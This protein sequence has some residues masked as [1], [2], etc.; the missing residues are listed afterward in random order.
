MEITKDRIYN[1]YKELVSG[2]KYHMVF[3]CM[4]LPIIGLGYLAGSILF[5]LVISAIF[6]IGLIIANAFT[7]RALRK[8][9]NDEFVIYR[10]VC[11][12]KA[13]GRRYKTQESYFRIKSQNLY[14]H[15]FNTIPIYYNE[16]EEGQPFVAVYVGKRLIWIYNLTTNVI[17]SELFDNLR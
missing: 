12:S 14:K 6:G 13:S 3:I 15:S 10:D 9:K 4:A 17:S 11:T 1:D 8:L 2:R 7:N 5:G 16:V